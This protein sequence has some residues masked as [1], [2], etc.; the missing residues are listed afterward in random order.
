MSEFLTSSGRSRREPMP[1]TYQITIDGL[2]CVVTADLTLAAA[3]VYCTL[4]STVPVDERRALLIGQTADAR[5][6]VTG[7]GSLTRAHLEREGM[8]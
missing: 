7:L 5:H 8:L 3:P 4:I 6:T 1:Q 2:R